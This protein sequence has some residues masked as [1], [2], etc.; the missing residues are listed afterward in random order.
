MISSNLFIAFLCGLLLILVKW[1]YKH[2]RN[3]KHMLKFPYPE[4]TTLIFGN[5]NVLTK[6]VDVN[7]QT[8]RN[9]AKGLYPHYRIRLFTYMSINILSPEDCEIFMS[10]KK[11]SRKSELYDILKNWLKE[12]LLISNGEK[13]TKRRKIL[14]NAFHFNILKDFVHLFNKKT[15]ETVDIISTKCSEP[16][17]VSSIVT[18]F[19][20]K[21]ICETAMGYKLNT[22]EVHSKNYIKALHEIEKS[23]NYR[24]IRAWLHI[25]LIYWFTSASRREA[26]LL[27]ILHGFTKAIIKERMDSFESD[28]LSLQSDEKSE[29]KLQ[30]KTRRRRLVLLDVLLQARAIDGSIDYEGI[31]EEVDTFMFEGHDT[32]AAAIGFCLMLIANH[33]EVQDN[34]MDEMMKVMDGRTSSPTYDDLQK[35]EY[36]ERCIKETLRLYPSVYFISRVAD[37]DTILNSGMLVPKGTHVNIHIYDVMRNPDIFPSPDTFDPDRFLPENCQHRHPF[38]Y[39]PFS[40]GPRNCIGQKYAFLQIKAFLSGVLRKFKLTPID[41]QQSIVLKANLVLR[42]NGIRVKFTPRNQE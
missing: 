28:V 23:F 37:E 24:M 12:G 22:Q 32:T 42:T 20:L 15:E 25:P 5:M 1:C 26:Q 13:W 36:M 10:T 34:I 40:A 30:N 31:C 11:H 19:T 21:S 27:K 9:F 3:M 39:I 41:T 2:Y 16:I 35:L 6:R 18:E 17:E 38:A 14:T 4:D 29:G 8:L 7:H 33:P